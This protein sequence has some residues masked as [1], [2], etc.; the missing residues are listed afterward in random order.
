MVG[1]KLAGRRARN[2]ISCAGLRVPGRHPQRRW[3]G[4]LG[5]C[6]IIFAPPSYLGSIDPNTVWELLIGGIVVC[7]FSRGG[8][9]VDLHRFA[10]VQAHASWQ[11]EAHSSVRRLN[12]LSHGRDDDHAQ[13]RVVFFC[14]RPL[15]SRIYG[16]Q[17]A[18]RH[19]KG[20]DRTGS[21]R[22]EAEARAG[23]RQLRGICQAGPRAGGFMSLT[24]PDGRFGHHQK[25]FKLPNGGTIGTHEDLHRAAAGLF[26]AIGVD[27]AVSGNRSSTMCRFASPPRTSMTGATIFANPRRSSASRAFPAMPSSANAPNEI[28]RPETTASIEAADQ[29]RRSTRPTASSQ[30]RI[31]GRA[32]GLGKA[33]SLEHARQSRATTRTSRSS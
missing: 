4:R 14:N 2:L 21:D 1:K 15:F 18:A 19:L 24:L 29:G 11:A 6:P 20:H 28:F 17:R 12:N 5:F 16:A 10:Q 26:A 23:Y 13:N 9:A 32:A 33:G 3:Q 22:T 7:S 8:R 25:L 30:L 27:Q 31:R